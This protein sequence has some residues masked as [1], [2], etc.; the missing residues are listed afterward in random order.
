MNN[1]IA[2]QSPVTE[3][4]EDVR[5]RI[6]VIA[7]HVGNIELHTNTL[8]LDLV[9]SDIIVKTERLIAELLSERDTLWQERVDDLEAQIIRLK[10]DIAHAIGFCRGVGH[11]ENYLEK[12]YSDLI[13]K[14]KKD[15]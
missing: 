12:Y 6:R 10:S 9:E 15:V 2:P 11:P 1:P 13:P 8:E 4:P 3:L 7:S 5:K 14:E